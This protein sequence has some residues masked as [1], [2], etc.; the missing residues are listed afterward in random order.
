MNLRVQAVHSYHSV[1]RRN[2]GRG[3]GAADE[4]GASRNEDS[5]SFGRGRC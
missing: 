2:Q 5:T 3:N 1:E 4:P